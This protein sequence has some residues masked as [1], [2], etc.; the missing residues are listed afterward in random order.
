MYSKKSVGLRIG[1]WDTLALSEYSCADFP[2]RTTWSQQKK[3]Q[4]QISDLT[5][6]NTWV[7]EED[8]H[9]KSCQKSW[10]QVPQLE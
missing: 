10:Y 2:S 6:Y 7:C 1:P 5:F 3:K 8:Q 4:S 9:A